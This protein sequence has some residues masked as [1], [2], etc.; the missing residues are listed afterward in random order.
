MGIASSIKLAQGYQGGVG[1]SYM[2][3]DAKIRSYFWARTHRQPTDE[4]IARVKRLAS[5][6]GGHPGAE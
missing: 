2:P 5:P 6:Q 4:E 3:T 1:P